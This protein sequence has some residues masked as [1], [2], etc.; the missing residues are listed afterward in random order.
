MVWENG[1]KILSPFFHFP[2]LLL[3]LFLESDRKALKD[4]I[5]VT[6]KTAKQSQHQKFKANEMRNRLGVRKI[7]GFKWEN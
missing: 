5:I 6:L 7:S 4:D 2:C 3:L 1:T